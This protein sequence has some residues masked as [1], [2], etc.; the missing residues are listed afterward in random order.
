MSEERQDI[1]TDELMANP[2]QLNKD[3]PSIDIVNEFY[4]ANGWDAD[5]RQITPGPFWMQISACLFGDVSLFREIPG[6]QISS[7]MQSPE[8]TVTVLAAFSNDEIKVSGHAVSNDTIVIIP[9]HSDMNIT[10]PRGCEGITIDIPQAMFQEFLDAVTGLDSAGPAGQ[11]VSFRL[12][13]RRLAALHQ[14]LYYHLPIS[15]YRLPEH[16]DDVRLVT[17]LCTLLAKSPLNPI[18]GDPYRR[19]SKDR[20]IRRAKDYI[21]AHLADDVRIPDLCRYC[22][23]SLSTL[24][25]AFKEEIGVTPLRYM[26]VVRLHESRLKLRSKDALHQ[27][28]AHIASK[29]GFTHMG[30]FARAYHQHFGV[31]PSE[32][33][34]TA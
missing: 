2:E 1:S 16:G 29:C 18:G 34:V 24:E 11:V 10:T 26:L 22:A 20:V 13:K 3:L 27:S 30:R 4:R 32:D 17:H 23:V 9:P 14:M 28:V 15:S 8:D 33:R 6:Q 12:G 21:D 31:L 25:R 5:Y 19:V 7:V